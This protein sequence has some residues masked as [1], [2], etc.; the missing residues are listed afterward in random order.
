MST[1]AVQ[2]APVSALPSQ[3]IAHHDTSTLLSEVAVASTHTV[4]NDWRDDFFRDGYYVVKGAIPAEHAA[5]YR[6]EMFEWLTTFQRGFK[7]EDRSTWN[8][9][10]LPVNWK[11]GMYLH[12]CAAHE[13]FMWEA[14]L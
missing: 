14:R 6:Q 7:W 3:M 4:Y 13:K 11:G 9:E 10:H 8:E 5:K 2:I 1:A 12:Y